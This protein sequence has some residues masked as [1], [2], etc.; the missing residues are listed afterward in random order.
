MSVKFLQI[1]HFM[2]YNIFC[3]YFKRLNSLLINMINNFKL[4]GS[5]INFFM[6]KSSQIFQISS[7]RDQIISSNWFTVSSYQLMRRIDFLLLCSKIWSYF[8]VHFSSIANFSRNFRN[9]YSLLRWIVQLEFISLIVTL[10]YSIV[11][12]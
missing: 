5:S 2:N 8:I 3:F 12:P 7:S 10:F 9:F 4:L 11:I 6:I 1:V